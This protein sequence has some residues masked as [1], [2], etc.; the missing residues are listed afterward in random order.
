MNAVAAGEFDELACGEQ[1]ATGDGFLARPFMAVAAT[2][3]GS[4]PASFRFA[5]KRRG[6]IYGHGRK[7]SGELTVRCQKPAVYGPFFASMI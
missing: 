1:H 2:R 7:S 4:D 6:G 3:R 5:T